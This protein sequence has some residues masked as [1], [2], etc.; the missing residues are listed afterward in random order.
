MVAHLKQ[1]GVELAGME[2]GSHRDVIS[3]GVPVI[4]PRRLVTSSSIRM[5]SLTLC[6]V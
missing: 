5:R 2:L 4:L 3:D 1:T 6:E